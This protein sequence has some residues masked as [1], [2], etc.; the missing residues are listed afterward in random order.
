ML[1]PNYWNEGLGLINKLLLYWL[2][3]S[4]PHDSLTRRLIWLIKHL[5]SRYGSF[6]MTVDNNPKLKQNY[7][8]YRSSYK[9]KHSCQLL[10]KQD[11]VRQT[12]TN[13]TLGF[14][15]Q[16]DLLVKPTPIPCLFVKGRVVNLSPYF[17]ANE[18]VNK[19]EQQRNQVITVVIHLKTTLKVI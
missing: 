18:K 8:Y 7:R 5:F 14:T 19:N 10:W 15:S 9:P 13:T 4:L 12:K 16:F 11:G 2:W 6:Y 17:G 3:V 1:R